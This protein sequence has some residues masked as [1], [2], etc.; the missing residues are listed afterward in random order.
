MAILQKLEKH[1]YGKQE[2]T[3]AVAWRAFLNETVLHNY[4]IKVIVIC[5]TNW[6]K[7]LIRLNLFLKMIKIY[8]ERLIWFSWYCLQFMCETGWG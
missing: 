1:F 5:Y 3:C 6:E 2:D 8:C 4:K 7:H